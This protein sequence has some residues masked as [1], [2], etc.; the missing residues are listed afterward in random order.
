MATYTPE[1]AEQE[2]GVPA[3]HLRRFVKELAQ[4]APAV[5]WHPGWMAAR[6]KN[7]FYVCRSIYIINA[8][9]GTYGAKGGLPFVSKPGDVGCSGLKKI[10]GPVP[11]TE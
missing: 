8:L 10:H 11:Q 4:A 3:S 6:Y 7:S 5:V 2:T 1:W 9:L